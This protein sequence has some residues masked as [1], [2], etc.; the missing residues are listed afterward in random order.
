MEKLSVIKTLRGIADYVTTA[1]AAPADKPSANGSANGTPKA[2]ADPH[3]A[4]G[5]LPDGSR[6]A[7]IQRLV[8]RLIDAPLPARPR[9]T[10][11]T[12][13][14]LI[15]DDRLGVARELADRLAEMDVKVALLRHLTADE[16]HPSGSFAA[17]LTD[18]ASVADLLQRVREEVGSVAGLLH[19][20]PLAE[21]PAGESPRDRARREVKSLYLLTRGLEEGLRQT[22][23][24]GGAV[25][26]AATA[27]GGRMGFGDDP[28]P[29]PLPVVHGGIA[30]FV[31]CL[32]YEWPEVMVRAVDFDPE[33]A[34]PELA[35]KLLAELGDPDGPFEV[36][37][38]D[39]RRLTW[40]TEPGPLDKDEPAGVELGP[41]SLVL[42][43]GGARGVTAKVALELAKRFRPKLVLVGRSPLPAEEPAD[44]AH[45]TAPAEVKAALMARFKAEGK[46]ATPAAVEAAYQRL[47]QDREIRGNLAAVRAAGSAIEY[48]ALDVRDTA[49]FGALLDE[50]AAQ[51][52][53]GVIHGAGVIDDKLVRDKTPESF[54]K[55][56]GTKVDSGLT[57][58][59]K[60]AGRPV[61]FLVLFSS[62]AG[63][64]GNR[65]QADYAAAN[66][67]LSKLALG[68]DRQWPGRVVAMD[69]GPWGGVG[70]VA[71]LEKHLVARGLQLI[72]PET[73]PAFVVEELLYGRKGEP[74]VVIA[75]GTERPLKPQRAPRPEAAVAGVE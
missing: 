56:F 1:L 72:S 57:L 14:L 13:T 26:L 23:P 71:D 64:Y 49:A 66:E 30:G 39:G 53:T 75:G 21:P 20:L 42:I 12:G 58:A 4:A 43:T 68:L 45:L 54:E 69:W 24:Q 22:G 70:M 29:E 62:L 44:T 67:I 52:L 59:E 34:A 36:G 32:G 60:L 61:K 40:Q 5:V 6:R 25:L 9:F 46:P 50:L 10:L 27:L 28:L 38:A 2:V 73:G 51:G 3:P 18:P 55:V 8:V 74:E 63:R 47:K 11:P 65:G 35:D 48:R 33:S 37:H 17:D 31:K 15:T 41:D 19:L 16:T 7:D